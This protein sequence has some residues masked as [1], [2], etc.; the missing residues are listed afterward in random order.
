MKPLTNPQC[1]GPLD[2]LV[3]VFALKL[4]PCASETGGCGGADTTPTGTL[5]DAAPAA[6][7]GTGDGVG[8]AAIRAK[9]A[10]RAQPPKRKCLPMYEP[11][12]RLGGVFRRC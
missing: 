6:V 2:S 10:A 12:S 5:P 3:S 8:V 9:P 1:Q 11:S 4:K 7:V